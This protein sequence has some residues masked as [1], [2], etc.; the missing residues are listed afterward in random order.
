ME[1]VVFI[2]IIVYFFQCLEGTG[3]YKNI[4]FPLKEFLGVNN[5]IFLQ[6]YRSRLLCSPYM[7]QTST[8]CQCE[9]ICVRYRSCCADYHWY[10]GQFNNV[11]IYKKYLIELSKSFKDHEC[12]YPFYHITDHIITF[13]KYYT[14][15]SCPA[16]SNNEEVEACRTGSSAFRTSIPVRGSDGYIYQNMYCARCNNVKEFEPLPV[17]MKCHA[18]AT[19]LG[20]AVKINSTE[21]IVQC[22][23]SYFKVYH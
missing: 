18:N 10:K 13:K 12:S 8:C 2:L 11:E 20:C 5:A 14:V 15:L 6:R 21:N 1:N 16:T 3:T 7:N 23:C 19:D 17:H 9:P 22:T 4:A